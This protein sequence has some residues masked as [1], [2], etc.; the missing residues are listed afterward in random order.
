MK[1]SVIIPAYNEEENINILVNEIISVLSTKYKL[2]IIVVDDGSTDET[3]QEVLKLKRENDGIIKGIKLRR[4]FGQSAAL[5]AGFAHA[6]GEVVTALD[7]DLQNDPADIPQLIEK[8]N[9]GYDTV[10][11]WRYN[12]KDGIMKRLFSK[13]GYGLRRIIIKDKIHDSGCTLKAYKPEVIK[14]LELNGEMH[15]YICEMLVLKGYK[16]TEMKV[17]HRPRKFGK[18]KYNLFR[19]PKGFLDLLL[20]SYRQHYS[21]RPLHLLGGLGLFLEFIGFCLGIYLMYVKF[22]FHEDIANRPLLLL[23][24]LMIILGVQFIILGFIADILVKID[25]TDKQ[26]EYVIEKVVD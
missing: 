5:S 18:T 26:Q 15:R 22:I 21:K 10:S 13:I 3:W 11:G 8:L 19:L 25:Y 4:N 9:E 7:A 24:V 12:R 23:A 20:I 6:N 1:L 17:D 14:E 2:E 16:V